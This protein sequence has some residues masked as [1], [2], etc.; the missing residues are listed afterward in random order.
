MGQ[1]AYGPN[2]TG[3]A[4]RY[5]KIVL[6]ALCCL[7]MYPLDGVLADEKKIASSE[8]QGQ[9]PTDPEI[10]APYILKQAY[11]AAGGD[12]WRRPQSLRMTGYAVFYSGTTIQRYQPY[13]MARV[14]A[15]HKQAA[16]QANGKVRIEAMKDG[17]QV[18]VIAFD[19]RTTYNAQG[20]VDD[21]SANAQWAESFGFGAIRHG[22]DDGWGQK[23][24]PDDMVDGREAYFIE[25]TDP[26]GGIT[27][28]GIAQD[29]Y[30]ILSVGFQTQRG[31]HERRYSNFFTKPDLSWRQPGRVRLFY[32]GIK[33]NEV[34]WTDFDINLE[35]DDN[36]FRVDLNEVPDDT[37]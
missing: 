12:L 33:Q 15:D 5:L 16:H 8:Y 6:T 7:L 18:F 4:M 24:L 35:L 29:N 14:Y 28:F 26:E 1:A 19:G 37:R 22:L 36:L 34:I 23:R 25:L 32:D 11:H 2:F 31:W 21:Q 17:Q 10:S 20:P 3:I 13:T 27:Q 9:L 30:A